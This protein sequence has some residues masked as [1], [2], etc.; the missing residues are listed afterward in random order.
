MITPDTVID[1]PE[2]R[3]FGNIEDKWVKN[4]EIFLGSLLDKNEIEITEKKEDI[5]NLNIQ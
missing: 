4:A 1:L 5:N 2:A 3:E